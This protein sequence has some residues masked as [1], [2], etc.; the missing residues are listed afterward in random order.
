MPTSSKRFKES[1][2]EGS[3]EI[4]QPFGL[5]DD[6]LWSFHNRS[7]RIFFL[8]RFDVCLRD[9]KIACFE[10]FAVEEFGIGAFTEVTIKSHNT[11]AR[12]VFHCNHKGAGDIEGR[13]AS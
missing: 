12:T 8:E 7:F 6:R 5:Q 1:W 2:L 9:V 4:L 13:T 3:H 11:F 10:V